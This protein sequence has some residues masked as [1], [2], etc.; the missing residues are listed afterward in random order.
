MTKFF[1]ITAAAIAVALLTLAT[2]VSAQCTNCVGDAN[3]DGQV[4]V[5]EVLV[6]VN[7]ALLG[8]NALATPTGGASTPTPTATPTVTAEC[9]ITSPAPWSAPNWATNASE[10]LALRAALTELTGNPAMRGAEQGTVVLGGVP[11]L[12]ELYHTG[13]V[14]LADVANPAFDPIV[15]DAF[16]EFIAL[17]AASPHDPIVGGQWS[18]ASTGGIY[19]NSDRGL[20]LGGIEVRQIVDKG[21][22]AGGA[23]YP[24]AVSLTED[25]IDEATIDAIAA[26]WG[27]NE[28]LDPAGTLVHSAS[29]SRQMGFHAEMA[30]ALTAAKA[31]AGD[32]ACAP[33]RDEALRM[34][35]RLWEQSMLAR[36]VFYANR[37]LTLAS[38]ATSDN[39]YIEALHQLGEGG[40]LAI[41]FR[42][43]PDPQSGPLAGEGRVISDAQLDQVLSALRINRTDLNQSTTA[44]FVEDNTAFTAAVP[45]VEQ[46]V[47]DA[48]DLDAA[49]IASY[50]TPTAG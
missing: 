43:L 17:I 14:S 6:A 16:V 47:A 39:D 31:Y 35:F 18:P 21:L 27:A 3:A 4:T 24:Y 28:N 12:A 30:A 33:Q 10:A 8:C 49:E 25:E 44:D 15:D 22:F 37:G 50:R 7:N 2:A 13:A 32:G 38:A 9:P 29:Y 40:G 41:G 5:D 11:H 20:N 19:G 26:A 23:L 46:A 42:G 45:A 36:T 34:F 1:P 48:Y